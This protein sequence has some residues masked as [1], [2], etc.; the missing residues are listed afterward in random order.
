MSQFK[1][2]TFSGFKKNGAK[3][4]LIKCIS[5]AKLESACYWGAE[6]ICSGH[7]I[8][9]WEI[10]I[11]YV[12]RNVHLGN[13]KLPIYINN[14]F[15]A[16]KEILNNGYIDDEIALRNNPNVRGIFTE[17][18]CILC[19]SRK[20][21]LYEAIQIDK[22]EAF[23]MAHISSKLKAPKITYIDTIFIEDDL[24]ELFI[25]VN[26][27]SFH[28]SQESKNSVS[29][30][31][32]LEWIIEYETLCKRRKEKCKCARRTFAPVLDK[33]QQDCIWLIWDVLLNQSKTLNNK[34]ITKIVGSL[35]DI[36]CIKYSSGTTRRRRYVVYSAISLLT[37]NVELT[38]EI[39]NNHKQI[40]NLV[41]KQNQVYNQVKQNEHKAN[42]DYLMHGIQSSKSNLEKTI[43]RLEKMKDMTSF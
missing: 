8:D 34:L 3:N 40:Q 37:E 13:P 4:E 41:A 30:C 24:K 22:A 18:I 32:W 16:F 10:I 21:H 42:V 38:T 9:L 26:E 27:F 11:L 20:K 36:F 1:N 23:N 5:S 28:V 17:I 14:R 43:E 29:A 39:T 7:F 12:T 31:Y 33:Y 15:S 19:F 35:L 25:A 2:I 6:F